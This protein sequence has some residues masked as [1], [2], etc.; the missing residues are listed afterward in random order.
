MLGFAL[1]IV[2]AVST[3]NT[4][5]VGSQAEDLPSGSS[6]RRKLRKVQMISLLIMV[7]S[8]ILIFAVG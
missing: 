1:V 3:L 6:E 7:I 4:I 8:M 2:C 5:A